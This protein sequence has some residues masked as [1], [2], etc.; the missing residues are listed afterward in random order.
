MRA[1]ATACCLAALALAGC[2]SDDEE[3]PAGPSAAL[4]DLT[5]TVDRD[6]DG[7]AAPEETRVECAAEGDSEACRAVAAL[8]AEDFE[9]VPRR[10]ACTQQF[11]GPQTAAVKGTLRGEAVDA[12][13]SRTNGCEISRWQTAAPLLEASG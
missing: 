12:R 11:G 4:A 8:D 1:L 6:G 13:F 9:P 5:V 10:T 3:Q 2:G 7:G